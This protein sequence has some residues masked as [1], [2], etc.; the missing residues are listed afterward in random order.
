MNRLLRAA[1]YAVTRAAEPVTVA[2]MAQEAGLSHSHF[3]RRFKR[4]MGVTPA[5]YL[6]EARLQKAQL[7]L[8]KS[9]LPITQIAMECGFSSQSSFTTAFRAAF[10]MTP[11]RYRREYGPDPDSIT[12]CETCPFRG[13]FQGL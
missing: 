6:T 10:D 1:T 7:M 5:K 13:M 12:L 8:V 11:A 2:D 9:T 4:V 3:I